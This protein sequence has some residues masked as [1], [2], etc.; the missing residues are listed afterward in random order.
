M[1]TANTVF[2]GSQLQSA[3]EAKNLSREELAEQIAA[4]GVRKTSTRQIIHQWEA[5]VYAPGISVLPVLADLLDLP[6]AF[7]YEAGP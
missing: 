5:G 6:P 1:T 3:R 7:F 2:S 4:T